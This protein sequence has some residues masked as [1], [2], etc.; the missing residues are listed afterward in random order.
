MERI[1]SHTHFYKSGVCLGLSALPSGNM[2]IAGGSWSQTRNFPIVRLHLFPLSPLFLPVILKLETKWGNQR[3]TLCEPE[4]TWRLSKCKKSL[5][6]TSCTSRDN[7]L[8]FTWTYL[9]LVLVFEMITHC[10]FLG[11]WMNASLMERHL[12]NYFKEFCDSQF[13]KEI[14]SLLASLEPSRP[15]LVPDH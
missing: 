4:K 11:N 6:S 12:Y 10:L 8:G 13:Q 3:S 2:C 5:K 14:I 9:I 1:Y 15:V 7:I